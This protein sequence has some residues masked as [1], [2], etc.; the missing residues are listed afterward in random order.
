MAFQFSHAVGYRGYAK[1]YTATKTS[2]VY[3]LATGGNLSLDQSAI[4]SSGVWGAGYQNAAEQIAWAYNYLELKGGINYELTYGSVWDVLREFALEDRTNTTNKVELR[5]DGANGFN[6]Q[7]FCESMSFSCSEGS[8][9]TGDLNF[10]GDAGGTDTITATGTPNTS[11]LGAGGSIAY[12]DLGGYGK[13]IPYW[14]TSVASVTDC[15]SWDCSYSSGIELL[16]CCK[17]S[18]TAPEG[19]D[20][21]LLG[22]MSADGS[23]T[24]FTLAGDFTPY[25]YH[26]QKNLTI[27]IKQP[28]TE[29]TGDTKEIAS[30][31]DDYEIKIPKALVTSGSTSMQTGGTYIQ[32]DFNFTALGDGENPPITMSGGEENDSSSSGDGE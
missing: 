7:A 32:A 21:I 4:F 1:I 5:P 20:Y 27:S 12:A 22:S 3:V 29:S 30:T 2:G 9:L 11:A 25:K 26:Q 16:K 10:Q 13:L 24:V 31:D 15:I 17:G 28:P 23:F 19:A 6:G 8:V 18:A 14:A